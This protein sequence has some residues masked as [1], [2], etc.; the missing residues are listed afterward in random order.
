MIILRNQM[1]KSGV[2]NVFCT[3]SQKKKAYEE[4]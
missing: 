2:F 3:Q 4:H 1:V